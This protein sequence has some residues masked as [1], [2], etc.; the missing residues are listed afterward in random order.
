MVIVA[1]PYIHIPVVIDVE[2][3]NAGTF[4]YILIGAV[5]V[6]IACA[7]FFLSAAADI[8]LSFAVREVVVTGV[9]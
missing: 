2:N 5:V 8:F 6:A 3:L 1:I 4:T 9:F 7:A